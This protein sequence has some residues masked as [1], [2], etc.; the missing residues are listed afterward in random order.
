MKFKEA[1]CICP[2][3]PPPKPCLIQ[4]TCPPLVIC[5]TKICPPIPACPSAMPK[6]CPVCIK[7]IVK[8]MPI[9]VMKPIFKVIDK[10]II[11]NKCCKTCSGEQC[12]NRIKRNTLNDTIIAINSVCSNK[13][14]GKIIAKAMTS[15]PT[16]SQKLIK[17]TVTRLLGEYNIF[18]STGNLTY[19]AYTD[20]FCQAYTL[21][22]FIL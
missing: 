10:P 14:L 15:N 18:C 4:K 5:Q 19:V 22:I 20:N 21:I 17:K 11:V 16:L 6:S 9:P 12:N 1:N 13:M 8:P 3:C 2:T 7:P